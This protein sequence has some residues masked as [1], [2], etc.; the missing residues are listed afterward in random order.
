MNDQKILSEKLEKIDE[1]ELADNLRDTVG[2]MRY[3]LDLLLGSFASAQ[4]SIDPYAKQ[5]VKTTLMNLLSQWTTM[6]QIVT[7]DE[8]FKKR[9]HE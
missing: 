7:E 6:L 8:S 5:E 2:L 3:C 4:V 9:I 1:H